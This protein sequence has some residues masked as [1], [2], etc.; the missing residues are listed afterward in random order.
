[1]SFPKIVRLTLLIC[2]GLTLHA[3]SGQKE[4]AQRL[5][6]DI[7]ATVIAASA[8]AAH[9]VP[10]QLADVQKKVGE[11]KGEFDRHDYAAVLNGAPEVLGAA[12]SLAT[13]AAARK[14]EILKTLN[15]AWATLAAALPGD[16]T[17]LQDRIA[18]LGKPAARKRAAGLD[19]DAAKAA[20][21]DA[22]SLW[23]K[24][25]AAFAAGNLDEAVATAKDV[26]VRLDAVAQTLQVPL[27][28]DA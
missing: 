26:K 17:L 2:V 11:L 10:D 16:V 25:Q 12:Q 27:P 19:V 5:L 21:G 20:L 3:C 9:Y 18:E 15:D 4:S 23:S 22:T 1:M 13:A 7:D 28:Q 6:G 8:E 24:A 14:D